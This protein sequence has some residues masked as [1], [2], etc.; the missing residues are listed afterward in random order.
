MGACG[1]R[2][3][4]DRLDELCRYLQA[5]LFKKWV[6]AD[7]CGCENARSVEAWYDRGDRSGRTDSL[8]RKRS[9]RDVSDRFLFEDLHSRRAR[10]DRLHPEAL[11]CYYSVRREESRGLSGL[12]GLKSVK[13]VQS[14]AFS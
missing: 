13:S 3:Q 14:A 4:S 7:C 10:R 5:K 6:A 9:N 11:R 2:I 8:N 12:N 1:F